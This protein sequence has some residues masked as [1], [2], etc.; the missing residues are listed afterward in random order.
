MG[1]DSLDELDLDYMVRDF[2]PGISLEPKKTALLLVDLQYASGCRTTGLGRLMKEQGKEADT[3]YRFDR[4][5][6]I[7]IPNAQR[8]LAYFREHGLQ[9]IHLTFGAES[10]DL[11]DLAPCFRPIAR[12][13]NSIVGTEEHQILEQVRPVAGEMVINKRSASPFNSTGIDSVLR[14]MEIQH[15]LIAGISTNMCVETTARDAADRGYSVVIV[16]D[17]CGADSPEYHAA[18]LASFS[19]LFGQ[20]E[21]MESVLA[22]LDAALE[23]PEVI[24]E[25]SQGNGGASEK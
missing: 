15:L 6:Q 5:E 3:K 14:N 1:S 13:M 17:C 18:T 21:N 10:P 24:M 12:A 20:V 9:V 25:A 23:S 16:D 11:R 22:A 7:V 2:T 8:M 19:R 4:Q